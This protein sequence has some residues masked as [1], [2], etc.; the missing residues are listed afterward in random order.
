MSEKTV[1][2]V[3]NKCFGGFGLSPKAEKLFWELLAYPVTYISPYN[4]DGPVTMHENSS[5]EVKDEFFSSLSSICGLH[6]ASH[7]DNKAL[8][9]VVERLGEEANGSCAA[10]VVVEIPN[11]VKYAIYDY[12][13]IE[14]AEQP[15]RILA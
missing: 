2:I 1:K 10:L 5:E 11:D 9:E 7:R 4:D 15:R 8:V 13:G 3:L 14:N 12:D 6:G